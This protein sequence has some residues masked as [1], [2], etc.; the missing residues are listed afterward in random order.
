[1]REHA[2]EWTRDV[3]QIECAD[4]EWG[5]PGLPVP[6]E[7]V[8]L[9]AERQCAL[10][11]LL[12]ERAEPTRL[13]LCVDDPRDP[14]ASE[15][16]HELVLEIGL[17]HVE[18]ERLQPIAVDGSSDPS[19]LERTPDLVLLPC[20]AQTGDLD[21]RAD[22]AEG[23]AER[24]SASDRDHGDALGVQVATAPFGQHLEREPVADPLHEYDGASG[25]AAIV[26]SSH[27]VTGAPIDEGVT[28]SDGTATDDELAELLRG[29]AGAAS[30]LIRGDIRA[31][32]AFIDHSDDYTL[33]SPYGGDV[34]RGFDGSEGVI[35]GLERFFQGGEASLEVV[36]T[37]AS[38]DLAVL[39][40]VERQRGK[41]GNLPEQDW[42]LR[43]TLVFR[44][45]GSGWQLVHRHADPL[46]HGIEL[47]RIAALA[48]GD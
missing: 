32:L 28:M 5:V 21:V 16:T 6:H 31:Y 19:S 26:L 27:R 1:V 41:V 7:P 29:T 38:G 18:A 12:L 45:S 4:E 47:E 10:L 39:V 14:L 46:V 15:R 34:I 3:V 13:A 40:V 25:H 33:M 2:V 36:E 20:I 35:E 24:V 42:S 44:R 8:E 22:I 17:A 9:S 48:R 43:V 11:G 30:A 37:Y 23:V